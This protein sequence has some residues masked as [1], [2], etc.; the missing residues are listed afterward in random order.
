MGPKKLYQKARSLIFR[1]RMAETMESLED[2]IR[3]SLLREEKD[4]TIIGEFKISIK[5]NGQIEITE[6]PILNLEQLKLPLA[7]VQ[8]ELQKGGEK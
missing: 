2:E 5:G 7:I 3:N 4:K 1:R 8:Q 6:L